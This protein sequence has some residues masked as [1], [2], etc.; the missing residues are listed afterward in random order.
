MPSSRP[1]SRIVLSVRAYRWAARRETRPRPLTAPR[2]LVISSVM[3]A[4]KYS[5]SAGPRFS[6]GSTAMTVGRWIFPS[7][8][9]ADR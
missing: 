1:I 4:A 7:N 9:P 6:N 8:V 5:S 2:R 3:P